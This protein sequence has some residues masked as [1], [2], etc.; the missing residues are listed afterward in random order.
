M[1]TSVTKKRVKELLFGKAKNPNDPAVHQHLSLIAFLAWV[2]LGADGLSSACYGPEAS[3]KALGGYSHLAPFLALATMVTVSILSAAY[4]STI[5]AFPSG[6]GGYTVASSTLGRFAGMI[7]GC[8]LV[9]DYVLTV[10]ISVASGADAIFSMS[11]VPPGWGEWKHVTVILAIGLL[12]VM[13]F[14]GVKD[15]VIILLPIF[16]LFLIIHAGIIL[17]ALLKP[18]NPV[19]G[20]LQ[21]GA[22]VVSL[23][24]LGTLA[25]SKLLMKAYSH[26]AGT[27]TG[28]EAISNSLSILRELRVQT[29][30][31]AMLYMAVSLS[32]VAGGLLVAYLHTNVQPDGGKTFNAVLAERILGTGLWGQF[33]VPLTL[34]SEATLLLCAA[35]AGFIDGPRVLAS[36]AVDSWVPRRFSRLSDRLVISNGILLIGV[37]GLI[38]IFLTRG[39]VDRLV[40]IYSFSVFVTFLLSQMGMVRYWFTQAPKKAVLRGTVSIVAVLLSGTILASLFMA[41]GASYA[42]LAL[43]SIGVLALICTVVRWHYQTVLRKLAPLHSIVEAAEADPYTR[44]KSDWSPDA[45]TAVFLV[46]GYGG[47]GLHTV[48]GVKGIFP[49]FFRQAII[50][51][52]GQ[53]DFDRFKGQ[54]EVE[55]MKASVESDVRKYV[56]LLERWGICAE[57]R[58]GFGVDLINELEQISVGISQ[59]FPRAVYFCGDLVFRF[60]SALAG[61]L[62]ARTGEELQR[63]FR[64]NGLPLIVMPIRI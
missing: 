39:D 12:M 47:A 22:A 58:T 55:N 7:C 51:S 30:R 46:S 63:R 2:G 31:R 13:N 10:A 40:I 21:S 19:P 32:L 60:P 9:V 41:S 23:V 16:I 1:T 4:S 18:G 54:H 17:M 15:S 53:L 44:S 64:E 34:L 24:P 33:M 42:L 25:A 3:F 38:A 5:A 20:P 37:G 48:M 27:Y 8:A 29:A 6:G 57:H 11:F 62:H 56:T 14:R 50:V 59:Q 61:L 49:D 36:M 43:A 35:Q 28:I 52:V 26:G 45:P